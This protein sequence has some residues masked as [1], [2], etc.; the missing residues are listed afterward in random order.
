MRSSAIFNGLSLIGAGLGILIFSPGVNISGIPLLIIP[1]IWGML[2]VAL[3]SIRNDL[4]TLI[5]SSFWT[6]VGLGVILI[7]QIA[8]LGFST[9]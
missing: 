6:S 4:G 8:T 3:T 9:I 2:G 7:I 5:C 1:I